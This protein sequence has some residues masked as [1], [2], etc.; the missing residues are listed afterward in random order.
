[1]K[2][3]QT[4]ALT[5]LSLF[6]AGAFAQTAAS[7]ATATPRIDKREAAQQAKIEQGVQSGALTAKETKGLE[8]QQ[9]HV[10][11]VEERAKADGT[12]TAAERKHVKHA[13]NKA[14][15]SIRRQKHDAQTTTPAAA[16]TK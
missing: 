5:A 14:K 9:A 15:R 7:A 16:P 2:I 4:L 6:A 10:A 8:A 3:R 12:V 13:E 11:N 1:M